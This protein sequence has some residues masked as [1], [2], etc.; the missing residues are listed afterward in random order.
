MLINAQNLELAFKGFKTLFTEAYMAAPAQ[1]EKIFMRVP[2][3]S[4]DE[5]YGWLGAFPNMREWIGPRV[6]NNLTSQTFTIKNRTFESTVGVHRDNIAD[7]KLGLFKPV[8]QEMGQTAKRHPDELIF[9]LLAAGFTTT[10]YDGQN[11]FDTD[12]PVTDAS[13]ADIQ[14]GNMQAG[15]GPAWYL[16]D[17]S[18]AIRPMIWQE[19]EGYEFQTLANASDPNV[20]FNNEYIYGIHARV[21]A[22]FGLWQLAFGSKAEL[23]EENYAAARAAM[24]AF[25]SDGGR[26]LGVTPTTLVVPPS[27]ESKALA[28]LNTEHKDGGGSNPWKGTA[29]TIVTPYLA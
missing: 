19:R 27:L 22:G 17:T 18:R 13:G 29:E 1:A 24:M 15:S 3:A 28:L 6:I 12:H 23:N 5:T 9:A 11:F 14:I 4:A 7:D 21:N 16:L 26:L 8:F 25:K 20:F 10:C 2:S